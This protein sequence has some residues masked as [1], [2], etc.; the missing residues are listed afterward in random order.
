MR[1]ENVLWDIP[2]TSESL[3]WGT[4][5]ERNTT[6][7]VFKRSLCGFMINKMVLSQKSPY[8]M[9]CY[10]ISPRVGKC[11]EQWSWIITTYYFREVGL[12]YL[13]CIMISET[14]KGRFTNRR[15]WGVS[16]ETIT[17][18]WNRHWKGTSHF[19]SSK[20]KIYNFKEY[21]YMQCVLHSWIWLEQASQRT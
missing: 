5:K 3:V 20:H 12:F 9:K 18:R 16:K 6:W 8:V 17:R 2:L 11:I 14:R 10:Q 7:G 15:I 1:F 21:L 13:S 4:A 19:Y